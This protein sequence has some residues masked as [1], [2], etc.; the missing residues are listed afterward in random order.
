[1]DCNWRG[2]PST[3]LLFC[4][5]PM[6]TNK[7][8]TGTGAD[9]KFSAQP[10]CIQAIN[11]RPSYGGG[12]FIDCNLRLASGFLSAQ[13]AG[14]G[15]TRSSR[16]K[17]CS[18]AGRSRRDRQVTQLQPTVCSSRAGRNTARTTSAVVS[19]NFDASLQMRRNVFLA[20][21]AASSEVDRSRGTCNTRSRTLF[22]SLV[23]HRLI[24]SSL[25]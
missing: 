18:G 7:L 25:G 24:P 4:G 12:S 16:G 10:S 21:A 23:S 8:P 20:S 22:T 11:K 19:P 2:S 15:S 17:S 14:E 5:R 9:R 3:K 13:E 6:P 1:M